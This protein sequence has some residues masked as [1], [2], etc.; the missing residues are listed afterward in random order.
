MKFGGE[1]NFPV[2]RWLNKGLIAMLDAYREHFHHGADGEV[3]G[4][5][6]H[7]LHTKGGN[8]DL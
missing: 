1:P 6:G 3:A 2:A 7:R 5:L 4:S 8:N